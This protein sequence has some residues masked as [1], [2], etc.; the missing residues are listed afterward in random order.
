[1]SQSGLDLAGRERPRWLTGRVCLQCR[2]WRFLPGLGS[3]PGELKSHGPR[4][5]AGYSAWGRRAR[6]ILATKQQQWPAFWPWLVDDLSVV[7]WRPA[8]SSRGC[9]PENWMP[10]PRAAVPLAGQ[11]GLSHVV[12][13]GF[14]C[15]WLQKTKVRICTSLLVPRPTHIS[16]PRG[17]EKVT[18]SGNSTAN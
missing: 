14:Q 15:A 12:A 11:L 2:R 10:G 18:A 6:H 3:S 7:S 5:L 17:R 13:A 4:S 1:M 16:G 9:G 8:A